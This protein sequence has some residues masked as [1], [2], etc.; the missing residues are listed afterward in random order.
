MLIISKSLFGAKLFCLENTVFH[1][2]RALWRAP[3]VGRPGLVPV[4]YPR[5]SGRTAMSAL[6]LSECSPQT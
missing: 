4:L 1:E 3:P 6:C 2:L 5:R